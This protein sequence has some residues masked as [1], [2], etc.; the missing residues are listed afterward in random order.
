M[1]DEEVVVAPTSVANS[2]NHKRK[3]EDL[4]QS[5]PGESVLKE[6]EAEPDSVNK[7][8]EEEEEVEGGEGEDEAQ[9]DGSE[10]KRPRLEEKTEELGAEN[11]H[12]EE[13]NGDESKEDDTEEKPDGLDNNEQLD[14]GQGVENDAPETTTSEQPAPVDDLQTEKPQTDNVPEEPSKG[15]DQEPSTTDIPQQGDAPNEQENTASETQT[16]SRKMEVPNN[17]VGVLIGKGG[18]TIRHLQ[19]NSGAKIQITRDAES[20]PRSSTR[21]VELIGTLEN[22]EKA[23]RLIKDVIAE[24]D[25]GGSPSLVAK[26]FNPVQSVIGDQI[27][28]QVPNEK[29]GLIIGKGGETIKSL[30]TRS[31]ARIQLVQLPE[32]EQSKER[33]VRVTGDRKQIERAREMIQEVMDQHV[34]SSPLSMGYGQQQN[35][36]PRGP[37][38][39]Q[40][41][42]HGPHPGQHP[43]YD[44]RQRGPY[45]SH[46]PQYPA[47]AYGNYPP[48]PAPRSGFGPSWEQRPPMQGPPP[49]ANYNYGQP[50]GPDYG[51]SHPYHQ[52]PHGQ[53]YGPGYNDMKYSSQMPTQNQYGGQGMPQPMAYPQGG[54][55]QGY[56]GHD[57]YGKP[58]S[59]GM[60]PQASHVQHY[61]QP[62][63]NQPGEVPYQAPPMASTQG[64][65]MNMP[66]Q[67]QYPYAATGP[68]QQQTYP[69]YGSAP[70]SDGYTHPQP[71]ATASGPVYPQQGAQPVSGYGQPV[72]QQPP[73][74][75]Q[76]GQQPAAYGSYPSQPADNSA[77]YGYQAPADPSYATT[78]S[79]ATYNAQSTGQPGYAQPAPTQ[80][81]YDQSVAQPGGYVSQ[82]TQ[83]AAGYGNSV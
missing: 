38:A 44:Y 52:P 8:D 42:P 80:T 13:K 15:E 7:A 48:Q 24:A 50:H 18:E 6:E 14:N 40:W 61:S 73:A 39:P 29:V 30:Q 37:V 33:T 76:V 65:G 71:P 34:R 60:H 79:T 4:E 59:Y 69:P 41:G 9:A 58:P 22:I 56:S 27:E 66:P 51:Q 54:S 81:G 19:Y 2:D 20:D 5:A 10:A 74:Y 75:A 53:N 45:P 26:G 49:Q 82:P 46:S 47:P 35:F 67:Q 55:H 17:K 43:G 1:A 12:T 63:A 77:G 25:A 31:G 83:A 23:E 78:Q 16:M 32:G 68:M 28:M 11:G 3:L 72:V 36:R 70:A 21:S 57:Q 62:R 64:Y